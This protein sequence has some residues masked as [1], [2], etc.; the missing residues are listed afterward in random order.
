MP[1]LTVYNMAGEA[2]GEIEL[3]DL[4]FGIAPR[5]DLVHAVV[6]NHLA[7]CRQ[8]TQSTLTRAE[9]RGGGRKPWRQGHR[10]RP[11]G[12]H[13]C[14]PVASWRCCPGPQA[15]DYGFSLNKKMRRLAFKSVLSSKVAEAS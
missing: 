13:P 9:V 6:R 4:V 5:P 15:R 12:L 7:N 8:G 2:T 11:A 10:S 1:K 14:A 3:S